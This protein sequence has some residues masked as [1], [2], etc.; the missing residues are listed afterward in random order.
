MRGQGRFVEIGGFAQ[1][2]GNG[3]APVEFGASARNLLGGEAVRILIVELPVG[4]C[5]PDERRLHRRAGGRRSLEHGEGKLQRCSL[6]ARITRPPG[7]SCGPSTANG[8][9]YRASIRART[10]AE[11]S[12]WSGTFGMMRHLS[13]QSWG[14]AGVEMYCWWIVATRD[15]ARSDHLIHRALFI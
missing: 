14:K 11:G 5:A 2:P 9:P 10:V 12:R 3:L 15:R 4:A 13:L 6:R 7:V 1:S 8:S